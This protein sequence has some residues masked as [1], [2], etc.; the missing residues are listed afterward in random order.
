[1][2]ASSCIGCRTA[3]SSN[4]SSANNSADRAKTGNE[5]VVP[6]G[7]RGVNGMASKGAA[8]DEDMQLHNSNVDSSEAR[9]NEVGAASCAKHAGLVQMM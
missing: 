6:I 1:M 2:W 7:G 3:W 4:G 8:Q 5:A 9:L